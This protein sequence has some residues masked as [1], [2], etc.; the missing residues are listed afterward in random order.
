MDCFYAAVEARDNPE[1]ANV[2]LAVGGRSDRRGVIATCNYIAREYGVHSALSSAIAKK[3]CPD[4]VIVPPN[5]NKYRNVSRQIFEIFQ[6]YTD[7]IEPL[8][9][10]EAYLDVTGSEHCQ[11]SATLI[12]QAIKQAV[13][14]DLDLTV[15]A[16]V[17]PNKFLAKIASDW[18]KPDGLKVI[19]P[20]QVD[21][22]LVNLPVSKIHGVGKV[23][24]NKLHNL[25]FRTCGDLQGV[26]EAWLVERFGRFGRSLHRYAHGI[27]DRPVRSVRERKS[28]S[29]E[30]TYHHDKESLE[31]IMEKLPEL[32]AALKKRMSNDQIDDVKALVV[33]VKFT[34]FS[35][36][37]R[38][39]RAQFLF[40]DVFES[41]LKEAFEQKPLGVRLIGIG[42]KLSQS[43]D[44][45]FEQLNLPFY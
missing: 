19:T 17:A 29:V 26:N 18:N 15:S 43:G 14:N 21:S 11:G 16:G 22:F 23:T 37:T 36:I 44:D 28:I 33:K 38:E 35:V 13:K 4:L 7:E 24:A 8:S 34:D 20:Q 40:I 1:L 32:F 12:A 39:R 25:N 42:V 30:K 5:L 2:P 45:A 10:D 3:R 41:L 9:L 6:Y 31:D 27:D